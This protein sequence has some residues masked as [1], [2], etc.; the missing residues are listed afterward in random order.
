[1][2][3]K[4]NVKKNVKNGE[5]QKWQTTQKCINEKNN[6]KKLSVQ[7]VSAVWR[8]RVRFCLYAHRVHGHACACR[9]PTAFL[10]RGTGVPWMSLPGPTSVP[11][12]AQARWHREQSANPL[13]L[14]VLLRGRSRGRGVLVHFALTCV[15]EYLHP[16]SMVCAGTSLPSFVFPRRVQ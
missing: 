4:K 1:M 11:S 14:L 13:W 16:C 6:E 10:H 3:G 15:L 7:V 9:P 12:D 5:A 2:F 8:A